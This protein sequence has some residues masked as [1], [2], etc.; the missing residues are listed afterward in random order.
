MCSYIRQQQCTIVAVHVWDPCTQSLTCRHP[1]SN[2]AVHHHTLPRMSA[3]I[4]KIFPN[5]TLMMAMHAIFA[6]RQLSRTATGIG[7]SCTRAPASTPL[8]RRRTAR[9][10][11]RRALGRRRASR[12]R[13]PSPATACP[14]PRPAP[15]WTLGLHDGIC[16]IWHQQP[17]CTSH[18][19]CQLPQRPDDVIG[20][21][22]ELLCCSCA[23]H[24]RHGFPGDKRRSTE[25][26][27]QSGATYTSSIAHTCSL[28]N[29]L[30]P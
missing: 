28:T 18:T 19:V 22:R 14:R 16:Q 7:G 12:R 26:P 9:M 20:A 21:G 10:A 15:A 24:A 29:M 6:A 1:F 2:P 3:Q 25:A 4:S 11:L 30:A 8:R 5:R 17:R 27:H 13:S 23:A